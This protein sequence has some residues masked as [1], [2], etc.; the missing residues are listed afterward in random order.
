MNVLT[1]FQ[2]INDNDKAAVVRKLMQSSTPDF[3]FFYLVGLSVLMATLG[4]LLD[5]TSIVIGS[6]LL[7][8]LMYPILGIALG[9]VMSSGEVIGRSVI[10]LTKSFAIGLT[11]SVVFAVLFG[12]E[13]TYATNEVLQRTEPHLIHFIV[14]FVA[15]LAVSFALAQ[16]EWS[17][18]L[19]GIAISV[20]LIPPLA[21]VGV[22]IASL[23][24]A[25]ISG[26]LVLLTINLFGIMFAAMISFSLM[27][28][29]Q[30]QNIASSTIKREAERLME[31]KRAIEEVELANQKNNHDEQK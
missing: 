25:V 19:P 8:P 30:K 12:S 18:T 15:G 21:T 1:R 31:E 13:S 20:A 29:Y 9:L 6:M 4:L 10:T 3:D 28:L 14:A 17:E 5:S 26:S 22:G 27:N 11:L 2:A 23:D 24:L 7:A 16:P